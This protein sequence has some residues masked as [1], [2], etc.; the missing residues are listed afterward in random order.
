MTTNAPM[1]IYSSIP[2]MSTQQHV[3]KRK[4]KWNAGSKGSGL[5]VL[6]SGKKK[7]SGL[8]SVSPP[9]TCVCA[10]GNSFSSCDLIPINQRNVHGC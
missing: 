4:T 8:S 9:A 10:L 1:S 5:S 6:S 7:G 2:P 3:F